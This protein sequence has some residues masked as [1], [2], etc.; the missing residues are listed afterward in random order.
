[1]NGLSGPKILTSVPGPMSLHYLSRQ[2]ARESNARS[3]PRRL[4]IAV[5]CAQG[6]FIEDVDGNVFLD[7][8]SGAGVLSLGHSHPQVVAAAS[9]QLS[10]F[11][12]GLDLPTP[13]KDRF[14]EAQVNMLPPSMR[15]RMRIHFCG[16]TGA[17]AVEA[18]IKL[19]KL[20]TGRS[21]IVTFQGAFHGSTMATMTV[22]GATEIKQEIS[23]PLADVH[24]FP[25][26]YCT[27][28]PLGL[29]PES[30]STNCAT[31]LERA[32]S[33][34]HGGVAKPAAVL[35][36]LVQ[37]EGG[38]IPATPEFARRVR[39]VTADLGI[40]LIVDEVQTGCGRTGTWYAF[41][42]FGLEPD[43]IVA[44]K[45]LSGIG[46]P[47]S[48]I[49]YD[50]AL[51]RWPPGAHI[52]TFRGNQ[53]AFAAGAATIDVIVRERV[54]DNVVERGDQLRRRLT[55]LAMKTPSI[56]DVRGMGLILGIEL[57]DPD[58]GA[59]A[60]DL[61]RQIQSAALAKGLILEVGGRSDC[62]LRMLP[63]LNIT[64]EHVEA[65]ADL[66]EQAFA[67]VDPSFGSPPPATR[68]LK[69]SRSEDDE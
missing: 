17:N 59:Y 46:L 55:E 16:P 54:L 29:V 62:V 30:C 38:G 58:T 13:A 50:K 3:Y 7:F 18:A 35:L 15:D 56:A 53:L 23:N 21:S 67:E 24:F 39:A 36:E 48:I 28:C 8:L 33:D 63:A 37:G 43:V 42:Q 19:C 69:S 9:E 64:P 60:T 20:A 34:P 68:L 44:S 40:P 49:L 52:G 22:S 6:S 12:H 1:M 26:S 65:A 66:L 14:T 10:T 11:V 4:P 45:G 31:Y 51:D 25:Y 2:A 27:R 5:Q 47:V 57:V 61:A 32:L 41:E